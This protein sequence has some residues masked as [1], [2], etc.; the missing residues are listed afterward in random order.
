MNPRINLLPHRAAQRQRARQHFMVLAVLTA[1]LGLVI[2]GA[3]HLYNANLID[4]Q[5]ARNTFL[6][7]EIAK[8]DK[9]R[10]EI[11][12]LKDDI[13][14][15]LKRKQVIESL[16]VDR[17]QSVRLLEELVR[18]APEGI[19]LKS[20]RQR[21][22]EVELVGYAQSNARVSAMMRNIEGSQWLEQ[23]RLVEIKTSTVDKRRVS[24]F[25][26]KFALR[27]G[28][29]AADKAAAAKKG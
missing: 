7:G 9:E 25:S 29:A 12:R 5:N 15:L 1:L 24:E 13:E 16:Q 10:E 28:T 6:K 26:L 17:V 18:Q 27:R 8:L 20:V 11:K 14:A 4:V 21:G 2:V 22:A 23:P 3:V 19:Y